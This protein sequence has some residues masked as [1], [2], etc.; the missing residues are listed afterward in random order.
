V[1]IIE[2]STVLPASP[3]ITLAAALPKGD[4]QATLFSMATQLGMNR[5]VPLDCERSVARAG[6]GFASRTERT[7]IEACK[8]SRQAHLPT[9]D[10]PMSPAACVECAV[11]RDELVLIADP[12]GGPL[13]RIDAGGRSI[14]MLIGPEGGFT[15]NELE[16][17]QAHGALLVSLGRSILR[18]ETAAVAA[19][20]WARLARID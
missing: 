3:S 14:A 11:Q 5:F 8:Q 6:K 13:A 9:F 2:R 12:A 1:S 10:A 17:M 20:A 15:E 18:I 19:L 4:R 16:T 7:A